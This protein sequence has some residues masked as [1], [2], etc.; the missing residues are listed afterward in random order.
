MR[1]WEARDPDFAR[2]IAAPLDRCAELLGVD[3]ATLSEL[4]AHIE[5]YVRADG[6]K[7][8]SLMQLERELHPEAYGR[9]RAGGYLTRRRPRPDP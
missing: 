9:R 3:L 7:V 1:T 6:G 8:W 5:P 4:A 2:P